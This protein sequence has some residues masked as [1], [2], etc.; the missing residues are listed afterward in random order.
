MKGFQ[1]A[2][3]RST[4]YDNIKIFAKYNLSVL[5]KD[6]ERRSMNGSV[7]ALF[8]KKKAGH[9]GVATVESGIDTLSFP[10]HHTLSACMPAPYA[11]AVHK[12]AASIGFF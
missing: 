3:Q 8:W 4:C 9:D 12:T 2:L 10:K 7:K 6:Y 1:G 11:F 5:R